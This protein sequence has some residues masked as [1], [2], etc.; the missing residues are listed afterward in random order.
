MPERVMVE[1]SNREW[2]ERAGMQELAGTTAW[3]LCIILTPLPPNFPPRPEPTREL[4][5]KPIAPTRL[6]A[7]ARLYY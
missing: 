6:S 7:K 2:E 4:N 1:I 5:A 3:T